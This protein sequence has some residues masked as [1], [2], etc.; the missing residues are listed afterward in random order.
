MCHAALSGVEQEL[1]R[2]E[3]AIKV[4][5]GLCVAQDEI[6]RTGRYMP[7]VSRGGFVGLREHV[8][9]PSGRARWARRAHTCRKNAKEPENN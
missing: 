7:S 9:D 5:C 2:R 8:R 6:H 1:N 3:A 4:E